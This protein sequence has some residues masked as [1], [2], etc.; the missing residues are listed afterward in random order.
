MKFDDGD[1]AAILDFEIEAA[2]R[3]RS[4]RNSLRAIRSADGQ[5][6]SIAME[7]PMD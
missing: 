4:Y 2:E 3:R 1:V 5:T 6:R 7:E